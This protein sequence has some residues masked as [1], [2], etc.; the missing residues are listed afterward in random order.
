VS[1]PRLFIFYHAVLN[2]DG[3]RLTVGGIQT[4]LMCLADVAKSIGWDAVIVQNASKDFDSEAN[5]TSVLGRTH[6]FRRLPSY[7]PLFDRVVDQ[8]DPKNDILVWGSFYY[9]TRIPGYTSIAIQHG[10]SFDIIHDNFAKK[11]GL[12]SFFKFLQR[13]KALKR[14]QHAERRVCV[15]Y[16]FLNWYRTFSQRN[17]DNEI[18]V[19]PNFTEIPDN[20]IREKTSIRSLLFARR[21]VEKRGVFLMIEAAKR[22]LSK[23]PDLT[24]TFA[25]EGDCADHVKALQSQFEDR[26]TITRYNPRESLEFHEPFDIAIVP[27]VGSEGTSLSLLEAMAAGCGVV[28]SNV[29]GM[30]NIVI[31]RFNGLMINPSADDLTNAIIELIEDPDFCNRMRHAARATVEDGFCKSLWAERWAKLLK[32]VAAE[33]HS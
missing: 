31:D 32:N 12:G 14:F 9:S 5:G 27:T 25:G 17:D 8:I 11:I 28:C 1:Q 21:F 10:I 33:M 20:V 22:L 4:Y 23:Y 6:R 24:V 30:T 3:T 15:D 26:V 7:K 2:K 29:G 18:T 13:R 16:N 19:I